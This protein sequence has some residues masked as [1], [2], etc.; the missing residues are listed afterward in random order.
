MVHGLAQTTCGTLVTPYPH[1]ARLPSN[2]TVQAYAALPD[3]GEEPMFNEEGTSESEFPDES[4]TD[5][6]V[7]EAWSESE[8]EEEE[9]GQEVPP[10][11]A[12]FITWSVAE[13][14]VQECPKAELL[15]PADLE[16]GRATCPHAVLP[17]PSN[18][19]CPTKLMR[20][21]DAL[22]LHGSCSAHLA[23]PMSGCPMLKP[24]HSRAHQTHTGVCQAQRQTQPAQPHRGRHHWCGG[25]GA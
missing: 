5:E 16:V 15:P 7:S 8:E 13:G 21:S 12:P 23:I 4:D 3:E 22:V 11:V 18:I 2:P 20:G 9:G 6:S 25:C 10:R 19:P 17:V 14:R 1:H 24:P